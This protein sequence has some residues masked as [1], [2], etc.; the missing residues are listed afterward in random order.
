MTRSNFTKF[1]EYHGD[2]DF[3]YSE[4]FPAPTFGEDFEL[5][6]VPESCEPT[7]IGWL[8]G[9]S[10]Q[11]RGPEGLHIREYNGRYFGHYDRV[12]PRKNLIGHW[13][14]DA[15][16]ELA[17]GSTSGVGMLASFT[18]SSGVAV[19]WITATLLAS[20]AAS[21]VARRIFS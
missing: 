4:I 16:F 8:F 13:V 20:V 2:I 3:D 19:T 10:R 15:P 12:D 9:A 1:T 5:A 18:A 7:K 11:W 6:K 17:V 14:L 21:T